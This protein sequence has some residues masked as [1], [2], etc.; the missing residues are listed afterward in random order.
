MYLFLLS[1]LD[2]KHFRASNVCVELFFP[3]PL[4]LRGILCHSLRAMRLLKHPESCS[5]LSLWGLFPYMLVPQMESVPHPLPL[6]VLGVLS[7]VPLMGPL[8]SM[9]ALF[10][11]TF[12]HCGTLGLV[13]TGILATTESQYIPKRR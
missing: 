8:S 9:L 10:V 12:L 2:L 13:A 7:K 6:P 5:Q 4:L 3:P 1:L 11:L